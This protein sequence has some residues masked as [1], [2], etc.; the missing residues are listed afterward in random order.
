ME[1]VQSR[2]RLHPLVAGAAAAVIIASAVAVAAIGGYLPGSKA[3]TS[4][5][6]A[7]VSQAAKAKPA[8]RVAAACTECGVV[9]S[10][11]EVNVLGKGT[12]ARLARG[13]QG[14]AA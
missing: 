8:T 4:D 7:K 10:V 5:S 6:T 2:S 13:R 1:N 12:G 3:D 11:N 9:V 14:A